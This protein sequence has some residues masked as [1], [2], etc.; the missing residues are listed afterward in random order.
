MCDWVRGGGTLL[1]VVDHYPTGHAAEIL[2]RRFDVD[3]GKEQRSDR[4]NA[5][6]GGT[7]GAILFSRDNKLLADHPITRGRNDEE[8]VNQVVTFTG[9][10]SKGPDSKRCTAGT[11]RYGDG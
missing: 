1:L 6:A 11:C 2:A 3:L 4:A 9:S 10:R 5:P 7:G 8:R